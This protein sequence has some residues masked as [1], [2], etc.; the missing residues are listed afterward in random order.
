VG[1]D[2][3]LIDTA[4]RSHKND[5]HLGELKVYID[6]ANP[7]E[8]V[9]IM[10]ANTRT[11]DLINIVENFGIVKPSSLIF[12]KIDETSFYGQIFSVAKKTDL[13]ISYITTGQKVPDDINVIEPEYFARKAAEEVFR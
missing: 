1:Y 11:Q 10:A 2:A 4:G 3:V 13:A 5:L 9:L 7:E 12:T 8:R 6:T